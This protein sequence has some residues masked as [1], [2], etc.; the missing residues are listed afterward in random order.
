MPP[1]TA[2]ASAGAA[3]RASPFPSGAAAAAS[4]ASSSG[5]GAIVAL[6]ATG[7]ARAKQVGDEIV[8][9]LQAHK[10]ARE[11]KKR[12]AADLKN[13]RRRRSRLTKRARMLSTEDLLTVVALRESDRAARSSAATPAVLADA[14]VEDMEDGAGGEDRGADAPSEDEHAVEREERGEDDS[15]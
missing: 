12:L 13:A 4:S 10:Q 15:H 5:G 7:E 1:K 11:R 9:L 2:A 14:A 8:D 3:A 6:A